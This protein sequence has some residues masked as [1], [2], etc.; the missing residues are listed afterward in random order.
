MDDLFYYRVKDV[1]HQMSVSLEELYNG[2]TRRLALQKHVI[3]S[4]CE[5]QGGKKPPEKCPSCRG[6]GM[7]VSP[8]TWLVELFW[9]LNCRSIMAFLCSIIFNSYFYS[10]LCQQVRIQQ[11]GP[12][13]VS[14]VQSMCGEC[15]GQGERINSKDRCRTCEGRKARLVQ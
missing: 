7:Q 2:T 14:Q 6:T 10:H 9:K 4:K 13:M 1:I 5:G 3:C 8:N 11:L 15:R 12:G